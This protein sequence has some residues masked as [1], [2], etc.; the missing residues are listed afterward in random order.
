M[1]KDLTGSSGKDRGSLRVE[2]VGGGTFLWPLLSFYLVTVL[3]LGVAEMF[4][5]TEVIQ[6]VIGYPELLCLQTHIQSIRR[7]RGPSESFRLLKE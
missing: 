7:P 3:V 4:L 5:R 2:L 1:E 6:W